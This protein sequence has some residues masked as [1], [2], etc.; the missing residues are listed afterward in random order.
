MTNRTWRAAMLGITAIA[1]AA[2][3]TACGSA[4]DGPA[5]EATTVAGEELGPRLEV[6]EAPTR[7]AT[8]PAEAEPAQFAFVRYELDVSQA[9][10]RACLSF[11]TTLD[12]QRDYTPYVTVEPATPI[13]LSVEG[14]TLCIGGLTFAQQRQ[15]T[16]RSGLPSLDNQLLA[17]DETI[18]LDAEDRPAYVGFKGDG[19]IL[20]RVEADG[21]AL[22]TVNVDKVHITV[23]RVTDRAL[24]FRTITAGYSHAQGGYGY[25]GYNSDAYGLAEPIWKGEIDTPGS[26]N[27]PTTTVFPIAT[28]IARLQ[29][30][31]YFVELDQINAAGKVPDDAARAK[32][33]LIITDLALTTF[34]GNDGMSATVRS[35][36]TAKP[37]RG[38]K[39]ELIARNN[40]ILA[41]GESDGNGHVKFS[42]PIT[43]GEDALAPRLLMAYANDGDFAILD[44]ERSPVDLTE[45]DI[46]GRSPARDV[47]ALIYTERGVYRPG[48]VVQITT[49]IRDAAANAIANRAGALIVYG[50]NGL[51]AGRHRFEKAEQAGGVNWSF[52]VPQAAAR[53]QWR[54]ATELDGLGVVGLQNISVEDFV[55]Q[56]I[57]LDVQADTDTPMSDDEARA[58]DVNV[59]FLYG[60]PGAGLPVEGNTRVETDPNPFPALQGF[61]FGNHD[62]EFR[63]TTFE[64]DEAT[65]DGTGR[66]SLRLDPADAENTMSTR[67]LR[68]RTVVSAVEPGGRAVRDDV[69]IAYRPVAGYLG[70]KPGFSDGSLPLGAQAAFEVAAVDRLG[71]LQAAQINWR[72]V[73][74]DW[75]YD[76]YRAEGGQWQW[77]RSR[78]VV[79][80]EQGVA[81]SAAGERAAV[82]TSRRLDWGD[83]ELMLADDTGAEAS[84][85]FYSGWGSQGSDGVEAPD[86]VRVEIPDSLPAVGKNVEVT[87]LPPYAGEAEI[88]V[89][90]ENVIATRTLS[91]KAETPT[92][93]SLPVTKE[94]G[95]G[96][97]VMA[98]V[99]TPRDA[100]TQPK[101]RRAVGVAH[102]AVDVAPRTFDLALSTPDVQ[103]PLTKMTVEVSATGPREDAYVTVAAVDEGILLL[104]D[105]QTPD[106]AKYFFGKRR[107]GVALRDDYGRLLDPN[108]GTAGTI[109]SGGDQIGGA[110]LTVVPTKSV[111]LFSAPVQLRN[112]KATVSFDLPEFNGQLRL[113][114]I[115]W[116]A[117]GVGSVGKPVTVRDQVPA[118]MILPRFL[119]P[120]DEAAATLTLDNVEGANGNYRATLNAGA[121]VRATTGNLAANVDRGQR[122]DL[123]ATL[124]STA[125][126]ISTIALNVTG[127]GGYNISRSYPIQTRSAWMPASRVQRAIVPP[128]QRF[129]PAAD[130]L[131]AFVA[132]SGVVQVS[133]SPIPMD[134][135][136]LYDSLERYPYG[137]TEQITSRAMPLLYAAQMAALAGRKPEGDIRAQV[138]DAISTLLNR[139]AADGVFGYW[140]IGDGGST[141]WLG[142]Y[143]TDFLARAKAAGYVVPDAALDKAYD[144]LEAFAV[145]EST[146]STS[147][148]FDVY[149]SNWNPDTRQLLL[150]R[151]IAYAAYVLAKAGRMDKSRL[152]YLHDDRLRRIP[153]PL[154]RAQI[155]AGLYMIGDNARAGSA[156]NQA[157][158]AI[159]YTNVGDYYQTT[160]R[161]LAGVLALA[162]E[163]KQ[164][165]AVARLADRVAQNLPEPDRLTTQEKAFLLLA[166]NALSSDQN[167][168][169]VSVAGQADVVTPGRVFRLS[170]AQT[171]TPP[172]FTNNGAGQLWVTSIARGSPASAPA[173]A[174]EGVIAGKQLWTP[175]GDRI[176]ATSFRQGDRI[177]IQITAQAEE[178]RTTPLVIADLLPAGFEIEAVL[179]PEDAGPNG[180]YRF[181]GE[182]AE[183]K[184]AEARDDRFVAA[185]DLRDRKSYTVAYLVRAVTPGT[186]T[187]PGVVAE[188][189]Y[190]PDVF[191]RTVS[192]RIEVARRQ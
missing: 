109:R 155:A 33:W 134:A 80:I 182:L 110:G 136:A 167:Q 113:M 107:L 128:G 24:A 4:G 132:G 14:A 83:Y 84:Y 82:T 65:T 127:P 141:P 115:A 170:A 19:V 63:E 61:S 89:A 50:P 192:R 189:M 150:D 154:A 2:L 140:R 151:S 146:Y 175:D 59:R 149:T 86:R 47:D 76:W 184:I 145:R 85:G 108:M 39:L 51:E 138:Q 34:T 139:Q 60:A 79:D 124:T 77:R 185:L 25:M 171:Q 183:L 31:A 57:A 27:T 36:Q 62:E 143:V 156:F 173:P 177:V 72:L 162:A 78:N 98:N 42:G 190:R 102:I 97:Y 13:A 131:A 75:K 104:T 35:I 106:P 71:A 161:D 188:D 45:R 165:E 125:E 178:A 32:R 44:L 144:A 15:L 41:R 114:A 137:C 10:P 96:V 28:A 126:G 169:N 153:S 38:V 87:I 159:G 9:L 53:G 158:Q 168:V 172:S 54:I 130:S 73:R 101:P 6:R 49:L 179:R 58:I 122:S 37:A 67:P 5:P 18:V 69:R 180:P 56:R 181:L 7:R 111:A 191:A 66:A 117:S 120:G 93:I 174:S 147:Y 68:L 133:F 164:S 148:D 70:I 55:P 81:R 26:P 116:S 21:L 1:A 166:A 119:A 23:S 129:T 29:P 74:I 186:F 103:R 123:A 112:G 30:G 94:W 142:A 48:E 43:H 100:V 135:A 105:F 3:L 118:E 99:Y 17:R 22:E 16:L 11:S 88:V 176:N 12:P 187:M 64:L 95:A 163:A 121:P 91:V 160:R 20:P 40:E 152:R 92:K 52:T 46:G 157:E 8:L 90:S